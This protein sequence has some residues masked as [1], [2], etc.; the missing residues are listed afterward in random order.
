MPKRVKSARGFQGTF[1]SRIG[2]A[3]DV[4]V[5]TGGSPRGGRNGIP[6]RGNGW[7]QFI[8]RMRMRGSQ[9][10][11]LD[12]S[13]DPSEAKAMTPE[14]DSEVGPARPR[15]PKAVLAWPGQVRLAGAPAG[16][17]LSTSDVHGIPKNDHPPG[18][19]LLKA[20][21]KSALHLLAFPCL[22]GPAAFKKTLSILDGQD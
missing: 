12:D 1:Q 20:G 13:P 5:G 6:P 22:R 8:R 3:A 7:A 11:G 15:A 16:C 2:Q 9:W 14:P 17:R 18:G 21:G 10:G 19:A 4:K